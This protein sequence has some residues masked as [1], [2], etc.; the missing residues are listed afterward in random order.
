[1]M[2]GNKFEQAQDLHGRGH[3]CAQSVVLPFSEELGL[4]PQ[5]VMRAMEGFGAGMG[6]REQTCGA[7]SG[8]IFVAG[9]KHSDG[10]LWAPASKQ[11][12]YALCKALCEEF[13]AACGG[14][15][16]CSAIKREGCVSCQRCIE[17]GVELA[18]KAIEK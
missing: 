8:A 10:N 9:M 15:A 5:T 16:V 1:M 17:L 12:T 2:F 14:S 18:M 4:E 7:L 6:G 13:T 11:E 3:N